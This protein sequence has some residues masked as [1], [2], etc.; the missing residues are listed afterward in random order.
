MANEE[1]ARKARAHARNVLIAAKSCDEYIE[2]LKNVS[3]NDA[4][5]DDLVARETMKQSC[6]FTAGEFLDQLA[7]LLER[8]GE[9]KDA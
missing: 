5:R 9:A 8:S 2:A 3:G 7:I 1:L 4:S 6:L